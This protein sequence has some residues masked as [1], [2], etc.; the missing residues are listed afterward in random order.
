MDEP[1]CIE[2][3]ITNSHDE[4]PKTPIVNKNAAGLPNDDTL[5]LWAEYLQTSMH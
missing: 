5:S 3:G 4:S 2:L 1:L